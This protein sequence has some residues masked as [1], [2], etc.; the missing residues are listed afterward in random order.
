VSER[1]LF[2]RSF[3]ELAGVQAAVEAYAQLA[4][5][6][7]AEHNDDISVTVSEPDPE[8]AD[9]LVDE[10]CNHALHESIVRRRAAEPA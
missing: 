4:R 10:F 7:I 5:F 9:T 6:E 8:L 1:V 3:Y 2:S